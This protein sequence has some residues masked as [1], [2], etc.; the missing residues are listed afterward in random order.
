MT[1]FTVIAGVDMAG[2]FTSGSIAIMAASTAAKYLSVV[3]LGC[4][5]PVGIHMTAFAA[6]S[7]IYMSR[8][9]TS[10][11]TAI[12]TAGTVF[13]NAWMVECCIPSAVWI[14]AFDTA[15]AARNMV[16]GFSCC[17]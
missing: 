14:M 16:S 2:V 7:G 4:R 15:V 6:I 5:C 8:V 17:N 3:N 1:S 12:V 10:G 9:F 13:G 11:G